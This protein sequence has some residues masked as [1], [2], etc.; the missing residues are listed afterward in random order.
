MARSIHPSNALSSRANSVD[1]GTIVGSGTYNNAQYGSLDFP[2]RWEDL[3]T[4]GAQDLTPPSSVG[5]SAVRIRGDVIVGWWWWPYTTPLGTG[6]NRNASIWTGSGSQHHQAQ[7]S[8]WEYG[9]LSDTDGISHIGTLRRDDMATV[10]HGHYWAS[11]GR[12]ASGLTPAVAWGSSAVGV[13]GD[14]AFGSCNLGFGVVHAAGWELST[15]DYVDMN[16][17]GASR[18][19]ISG[20]G[21]G[22]QVGSATFGGVATPGMWSGTPDTFE[23]LLPGGVTG[24]SVVQCRYGLQIGWVTTQLGIHA[25]VW[26]SSANDW[27]DLHGFLPSSM[28]SSYA[29]D[30]WVD[31]LTGETVIV[32]YAYDASSARNEAVVWRGG[33]RVRQRS[34][35]SRQFR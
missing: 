3:G 34:L 23:S 25:A 11:V 9:S 6:Y 29:T 28:Q 13:D 22:Q 7:V 8:G 14:H 2:L 33:G 5:G 35:S 16:P 4:N 20:A 12:S 27:M 24:A 15:N 10:V 1:G 19:S 32:G 17:P 18:S 21:D 26:R 31:P 30:L